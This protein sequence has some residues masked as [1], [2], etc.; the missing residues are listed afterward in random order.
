MRLFFNFGLIICL[1]TVFHL[2][3]FIWWN[4]QSSNQPQITRP[5]PHLRALFTRCLHKTCSIHL[6]TFRESFFKL[7]YHLDGVFSRFSPQDAFAQSPTESLK[8]RISFTATVGSVSIQTVS[9]KSV[10]L[11]TPSQLVALPLGME[12]ICGLKNC[13]N[14]QNTQV[15]PPVQLAQQRNHYYFSQL[16]P[17]KYNRSHPQTSQRV[18]RNLSLYVCF[19]VYVVHCRFAW[20]T[21][22]FWNCSMRRAPS[23]ELCSTIGFKYN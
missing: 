5:I 12:T 9:V 13:V 1:C 8:T 15:K 18:H 3:I 2:P 7:N 20:G 16:R 6:A 21:Q 22:C 10:R 19:C 17:R 23:Q 4:L 14:I 11:P